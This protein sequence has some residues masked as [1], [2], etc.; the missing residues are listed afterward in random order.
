MTDFTKGQTVTFASSTTGSS[1]SG[2]GSSHAFRQAD[3]AEVTRVNRE[4]ITVRIPIKRSWGGNGYASYNVRRTALR[5]PN[6][7]A[8]DQAAIDAEK[9]RKK[10]IED[11]KPKPRP[12][13]QVPKTAGAI[14]PNAEGLKWF[15]GDVAKYAEKSRYCGTFDTILSEIG[16]PGRERNFRVQKVLAGVTVYSD[17]K[18]HSQ[19][20]ADA[21]FLEKLASAA[22]S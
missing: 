21:L 17:V 13:F 2:Y 15:W 3:T 14:D 11:A 7:E 16:V 20:E 4:T 19:K 12:L 22:K 1:A 6:N 9:A 8:W 10:A 18:A 5:T